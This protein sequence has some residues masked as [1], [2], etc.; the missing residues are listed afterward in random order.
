M[1]S[2]KNKKI[3]G[4][5]SG[6]LTFCIIL[7]FL[8]SVMAA[9]EYEYPEQ[10]YQTSGELISGNLNSFRNIGPN[11]VV[12]MRGGED[13]LN[14]IVYN[15][16]P[17]P[18]YTNGPGELK[19]VYRYIST[20]SYLFMEIAYYGPTPSD[21]YI[22]DP[23]PDFYP[24][25]HTDIF[26]TEYG[27]DVEYVH[28]TIYGNWETQEDARVWIDY[29]GVKYTSS[30]GGGGCPILSVFDGEQYQE[31]GLLDI[32]DSDGTDIVY[33]HTLIYSPKAIDNRYH[34]KLT[35]HPKTISDIDQ[36]ELYG[37]LPNNQRIRLPLISAI[38]CEDGQVRSLLR[39]SD[40]KKVE[41][42][43]A[44]YNNGVSQYIDLEFV[45]PPGLHFTNFVFIIEGNNAFEK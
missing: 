32:H 37:I 19:V 23:D 8:P 5:L 3:T 28:F 14:V 2:I 41:V 43:G 26:E 27:V 6:F 42:L 45:A 15:F 38:H 33:Q 30:G 39:K 20:Q 9:T 31:E 1:I 17:R 7:S 36:V 11:D 13:S 40:D 29:L 21:N 25:Y 4:L 18:S 16:F 24:A 35:E 10:M 12:Y 44:D 22:L 34:L